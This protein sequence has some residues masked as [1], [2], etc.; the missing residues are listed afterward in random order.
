[1]HPVSETP[2]LVEPR[3]DGPGL[4]DAWLRQRMADSRDPIHEG[5]AVSYR[6]VWSKWLRFLQPHTNADGQRVTLTAW[7][8]ATPAQVLAFIEGRIEGVKPGRPVSDVTRRRYWRLLERI[9]GFALTRGWIADNPVSTIEATEQPQAEDPLGAVL[10]P[11]IWDAALHCLPEG[12]G[13]IEVRDRAIVHILFAAAL[14]P[15][16]IR[17]LTVRDVLR[18]VPAGRPRIIT[19]LQVDGPGP[20]QRRRVLLPPLAAAALQEWL[21]VRSMHRPWLGIEHLFVSREGHPLSVRTLYTL[22]NA[23]LA[24]ASAR[25]RLPPPPRMGPQVVRNTALVRWLNEGI[26]PATVALQAGLKNVRGF[27]RLREQVN[28]TVRLAI[29]RQP[30]DDEV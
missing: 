1:M 19:G 18:D 15:Q 21:S 11:R 22:V 12:E 26:D 17:S 29:A 30:K 10:D 23:V 7:Q 20:R 5:G 8:D 9:Y 16:E 3:P 28:A 27:H 25:A 13:L 6:A 14:A 4:F 24:Q 2:L